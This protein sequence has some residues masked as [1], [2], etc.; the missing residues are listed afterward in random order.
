MGIVGIL[1]FFIGPMLVTFP[2]SAAVCHF[3]IT[4]KQRLSYGTMFVSASIVPLVLAIIATCIDP[5]IW[6]TREHKNVPE[7][8]LVMLSFMAAMCVLPAL[9]VI[10]YYQRRGKR[11]EN[12]MA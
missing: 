7:I 10:V 8:W 2:V 11:D 3:R 5:S 9:C 6:W 4:R 1:I 12:P